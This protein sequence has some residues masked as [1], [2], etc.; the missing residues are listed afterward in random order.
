MADGEER[1][2]CDPEK[3]PKQH[4]IWSAILYET[5]FRMDH[6]DIAKGV[7]EKEN[8]DVDVG[9]G[10]PGSDE[11]ATVDRPVARIHQQPGV[12]QESRGAENSC[13]NS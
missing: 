8:D 13:K 6:K 12:R 3:L 11:D 10:V 5:L 4:Q 7:A 1:A 9:D 2:H